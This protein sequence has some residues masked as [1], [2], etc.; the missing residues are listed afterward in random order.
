MEDALGVAFSLLLP[1]AEEAAG[2]EK[3]EAEE[4]E[5]EEGVD[6]GMARMTGMVKVRYSEM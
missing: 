6:T 3:E 2:D 1:P 4:E 5:E